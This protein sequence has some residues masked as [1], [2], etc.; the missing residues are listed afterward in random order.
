M[1]RTHGIVA[2]A[3]AGGAAVGVFLTV[4]VSGAAGVESAPLGSTLISPSSATA[5]SR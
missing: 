2:A 3:L 4:F 1:L 5:S